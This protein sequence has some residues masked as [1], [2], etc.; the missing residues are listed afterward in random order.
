MTLV[1]SNPPLPKEDNSKK[2]TPIKE[3]LHYEEPIPEEKIES[4]PS[5]TKD[6]DSTEEI[7]LKE[8]NE[9]VFSFDDL[10][11]KET[12]ELKNKKPNKKKNNKNK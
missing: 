8:S 10:P 12:V 6:N 4:E 2:T 7:P 5:T 11:I 1:K 3:E 9:E